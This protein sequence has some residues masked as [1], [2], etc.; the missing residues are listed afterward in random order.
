MS[1]RA[2]SRSTWNEEEETESGQQSAVSGQPDAAIEAKPKKRKAKPRAANPPR[3]TCR[4]WDGTNG[5]R[6]SGGRRAALTLEQHGAVNLVAIEEYAELQAAP[7]LPDRAKHD[8]TT[9]K[10][11]LLKAID[12][13]N[14][15][16]QRQFEVTFE[17][18]QKELR[19]H[20]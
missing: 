1:R 7:R 4:R 2:S 15:T 10:A 6:S 9:A 12:E 11:D 5:T 20:V 3:P 14:Q 19:L 17:Q 16:S 8:L 18:I 13:I